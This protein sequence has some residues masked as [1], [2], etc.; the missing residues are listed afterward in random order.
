MKLVGVFPKMWNYFFDRKVTSDIDSCTLRTVLTQTQTNILYKSAA[1]KS[2]W[3]DAANVS[4]LDHLYMCMMRGI[5]ASSQLLRRGHSC[6]EPGHVS[7]LQRGSAAATSLWNHR[8]DDGSRSPDSAANDDSGGWKMSLVKYG[9]V[10][11]EGGWAQWH[12][13]VT[14]SGW[15]HHW[16]FPWSQLKGGCVVE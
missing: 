14:P 2:Y 8:S 12:R 16:H 6:L 1:H 10:R 15:L 9:P 4:T 3:H 13:A 7:Q 11:E 5:R